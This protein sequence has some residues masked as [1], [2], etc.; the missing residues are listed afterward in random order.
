M[1]P[2][3]VLL[4]FHEAIHFIEAHHWHEAINEEYESFIKNFTWDFVHLAFGQ[5]V[6]KSTGYIRSRIILM[7]PLLIENHVW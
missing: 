3:Y 5:K 2:I 1:N 6:L 7:V 4:I